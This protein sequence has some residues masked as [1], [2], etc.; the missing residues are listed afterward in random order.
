MSESLSN[1]LQGWVAEVARAEISAVNSAVT[2]SQDV[3][4]LDFL[5]VG[6]GVTDCTAAFQAASNAAGANGVVH[7]PKGSYLLSA[8]IQGYPNQH[9]LGDGRNSTTIVRTGDYGD[10]LNFAHAQAC[11]VK[12]IFF[13]HATEYANL[14]PGPLEHL[15]THGAHIRLALAGGATID[16]CWMWRMPYGVVIEDGALVK[17]KNCNFAG[18]WDPLYANRQ[19]G[20]AS[21][22]VGN[23]SYTQIID[24]TDC[25]FGGS[26][27]ESRNVNYTASDGTFTSNHRENIGPKNGVRVVR[28]EALSVVNNY[29]SNHGASNF[30]SALAANSVNMSWK[31]I[32]NTFDAAIA[33]GINFRV[34]AD[35]A[36]INSVV[37]SGNVFNG[38]MQTLNAISSYNS[39]GSVPVITNFS[40]TGNTFQAS[41]GTPISLLHARGGVISGNSITGYNAFNVSSG[42]DYSFD[43]AVYIG[44][45]SSWILCNSN[46]VGGSINSTLPTYMCR[47]SVVNHS[48]QPVTVVP[49]DILFIK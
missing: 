36:F 17:I 42:A 44:S 4:V 43:A 24:I 28:C 23:T 33:S 32:G 40:I 35:G 11:T 10:T 22:L 13:R 27:S 45:A 48:S 38:E 34:A 30:A 41:V 12:R 3:N 16:D 14:T 5:A 20:I 15:A 18:T 8:T 1:V 7:V 49:S 25:Y 37:V 39:I 29:F 47:N 2:A 21:V 26:L 46:I 9:W 19:E 31:F 6:D